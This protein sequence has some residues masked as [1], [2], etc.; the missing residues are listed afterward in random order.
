[1]LHEN[2]NIFLYL[3]K[4]QN[5]ILGQKKDKIDKK[6]RTFGKKEMFGFQI[7]GMT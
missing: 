3:E 4:V 5:E 6:V 7:F 2:T 1:M